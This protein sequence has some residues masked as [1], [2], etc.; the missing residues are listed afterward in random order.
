MKIPAFSVSG[1]TG[2]EKQ[3]MSR[4]FSL[5][6]SNLFSSSWLPQ[7]AAE[8]DRSQVFSEGGMFMRRP[9]F[10]KRSV[11]VRELF[12]NGP[13]SVEFRLKTTVVCAAHV[14]EHAANTDKKASM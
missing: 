2:P 1:F 3:T 4:G 11:S 6:P 12:G 13:P 14:N 8:D 10:W 7:T 5:K 9:V